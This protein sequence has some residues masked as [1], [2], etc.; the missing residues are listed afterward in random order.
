M[1]LL[2][3]KQ[4]KLKHI[5]ACLLKESQYEKSAGFSSLELLHNSASGLSLNSISLETE[6]LGHKLKTPLMIA[7]MTGGVELGEKLNRLWA[8]ASQHFGLSFGVGSQRLAILDQQV[9][10]SF[11]VRKYAPNI[12]LLANLGAAQLC[13]PEGINYALKAY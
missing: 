2:Q 7:P 10:E 3:H 9:Q 5:D 13:E 6:F 8:L 11:I 4:A 1:Q 12:F